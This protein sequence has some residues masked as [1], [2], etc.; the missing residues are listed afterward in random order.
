MRYILALLLLAFPTQSFAE[1]V[2]RGPRCTAIEVR[3]LESVGKMSLTAHRNVRCA[4]IAYVPNEAVVAKLEADNVRVP[5]EGT[6][7]NPKPRTF[8]C[9]LAEHDVKVEL[10]AVEMGREGNCED[11]HQYIPYANWYVDGKLVAE[12]MYFDGLHCLYD[13]PDAKRSLREATLQ[14]Y[15]PHYQKLPPY[16]LRFDLDFSDRSASWGQAFIYFE[17]KKATA[18][19]PLD[20]EELFVSPDIQWK[21]DIEKY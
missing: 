18:K 12:D 13:R 19:L 8:S 15:S 4:D 10:H 20:Y 16:T 5:F 1:E 14:L 6:V 11:F 3:C 21:R 9:Q 17:G 7:D 2:K